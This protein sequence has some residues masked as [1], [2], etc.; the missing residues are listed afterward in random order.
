[1]LVQSARSVNA[2][3]AHQLLDA[4]L[5]VATSGSECPFALSELAAMVVL[6]CHCVDQG[7]HRG[8]V[9]GGDHFAREIEHETRQLQN[10]R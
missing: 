6:V 8:V 5:T 7:V 1:M 2:A 4:T 10:H 9:L 3:P